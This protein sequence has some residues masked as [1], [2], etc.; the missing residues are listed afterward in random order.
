MKE[1]HGICDA[2]KIA[3]VTTTGRSLVEVIDG[4]GKVII[5]IDHHAYPVGMSPDRA[6]F[7][8]K[9]VLNSAE[10]VLRNARADKGL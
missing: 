10:R 8:A 4:D 3:S 1:V 7:F 9:L 6:K 5:Q 2:D